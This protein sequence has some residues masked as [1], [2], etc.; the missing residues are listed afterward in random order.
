MRLSGVIRAAQAPITAASTLSSLEFRVRILGGVFY[1]SNTQSPHAQEKHR[2]NDPKKDTD[3]HHC[4]PNGGTAILEEYKREQ[5]HSKRK[6]LHALHPTH[7]SSCNTASQ[8]LKAL[9]ILNTAR[10]SA[11]RTSPD[12]SFEVSAGH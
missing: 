10:N 2:D 5:C 4:F 8:G 12:C 3:F 7:P 11:G 6:S 9:H 1:H